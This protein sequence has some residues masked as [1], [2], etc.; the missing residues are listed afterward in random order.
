MPKN[1]SII[2]NRTDQGILS[3]KSVIVSRNKNKNI[4]GLIPTYNAR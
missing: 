2:V 1:V 3:L 4:A